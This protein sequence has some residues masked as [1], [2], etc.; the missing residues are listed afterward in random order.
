MRRVTTIANAL[1]SGLFAASLVALGLGACSLILNPDELDKKSPPVD[2]GPECETHADCDD[3]IACTEDTCDEKGRCRHLPDN[4]VCAPLERCDRL[5]GCVDSGAQCASDSACDDGIDCTIDACVQGLCHHTPNHSACERPELLC[6]T[7]AYCDVKTGCYEGHERLCD[8]PEGICRDATCDPEDGECYEHW[9]AGADDDDDGF[10]DAS[11]GGD[12]CDDEDAA[13]FPG[14]QEVCSG[15]D[16]NCDGFIDVVFDEVFVDVAEAAQ[17]HGV[18][19]AHSDTHVAVA[20]QS[21]AGAERKT[22]A[23]VFTAEFA[24]VGSPLQLNTAAGTAKGVSEP[25]VALANVDGVFV[26]AWGTRPN[27]SPPALNVA[28]LVPSGTALSLADAHTVD[29]RAD[30]TAVVSPALAALH[31]EATP[32]WVLAFGVLHAANAYEIALTDALAAAPV[33]LD[34]GTGITDAVAL[35]VVPD[36]V[37][38]QVHVAWTAGPAAN[39]RIRAT[40]LEDAAGWTALSG[41][42]ADI[43]DTQEVPGLVRDAA[44]PQLIWNGETSGADAPT[45]IWR[46]QRTINLNT[47]STAIVRHLD[48]ALEDVVPA[49]IRAP[50]GLAVASSSGMHYLLHI[51]DASSLAAVLMTL[52]FWQFRAPLVPVDAPVA[53]TRMAETRRDPKDAG[54]ELQHVA[55]RALGERHLLVAL[56]HAADDGQQHLRLARW[57]GCIPLP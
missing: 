2:T 6:I 25:G 40:H 33:V 31:T 41:Y 21:G 34:A 42:P 37:S 3:G 17:L 50:R 28:A 13:V 52:E 29:V 49:S 44:W 55:A 4:N 48:G 22:W 15:K 24:P 11:C 36:A 57:Q 23:R 30:A 38:P 35:A 45:V 14:A 46:E 16:N 12:D 20:W 10:L 32:R 8:K 18:V 5:R 26:V 1:F 53:A 9:M 27:Q 19:V 43:S 51:K 47:A 54:P 39:K 56:V 7:G